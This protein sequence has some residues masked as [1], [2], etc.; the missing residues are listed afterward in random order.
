M[1]EPPNDFT[2][3][4][5]DDIYVLA[6]RCASR[7]PAAFAS[8]CA[9]A[10]VRAAPVERHAES[11]LRIA[12]VDRALPFLRRLAMMERIDE[13]DLR[14]FTD[15]DGVVSRTLASVPD[16]G[17]DPQASAFGSVLNY[18]SWVVENGLRLLGTNRS[19]FARDM[20]VISVL[21]V[22]SAVFL[23][24]TLVGAPAPPSESSVQQSIAREAELVRNA[25]RNESYNAA[26]ARRLLDEPLTPVVVTF[27][28]LRC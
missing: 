5:L 7:A 23:W 11:L 22:D 27:E 25:L 9:I 20:A 28:K 24:P 8:I 13:R 21:S 4:T 15:E 16:F 10:L 1:F 17:L 2:S 6:D 19:D 26:D 18:W 12:L 3:N 14:P